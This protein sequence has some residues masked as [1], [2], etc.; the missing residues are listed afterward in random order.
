MEGTD[1]SGFHTLNMKNRKLYIAGILFFA[2]VVFPLLSLFYYKAALN[3]PAQGHKEATFEILD[4]E[5]VSSIAQRLS[6][7]ELINSQFLFK[8]H[9]VSQRLHTKIQAG[10]YRVPA[11]SS[12]ADLAEMFQ[13]GTNDI[14]MTFLEGWRVEE[15]ARAASEMFKKIDYTEFLKLAKEKEG[16]LFPDTYFFNIDVTEEEIVETLTE[17]FKEKTSLTL[18]EKKLAEAGVTLDEAVI[19]AS[20]V[21]REVSDEEDRPVVAGILMKRWKEGRL[22]GADATTQYAV[23]HL[24]VCD[25]ITAAVCPT[26]EEAMI[27]DWWPEELT[28]EDL[29][30]DSPYNTRKNPGLPPKPIANPG[31]SA[32]EAV[33]N[34]TETPY[35]YYLTDE[36]GITHYAVTLEEHNRNVSQH[37]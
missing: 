27:I 8:A 26:A 32:L 19:F 13:H 34:Y 35:N 15:Y 7:D 17:T 22:L 23:A 16:F 21:E 29:S 1:P 10:V 9:V 2:L 6:E 25:P 36:N 30:W 37:L 33:L 14:R 11:G 5:S 31:I 20:I 12:V 28:S 3:R 24:R 18:K 4:G